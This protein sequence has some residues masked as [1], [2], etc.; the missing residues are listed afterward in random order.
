MADI[1]SKTSGDHPNIVIF[2]PVIL[3]TTVVL[4]CMLQWLLPLGVL[5]GIGQTWRVAI[6]CILVVA[7]I[8]LA[9]AGRRVLTGL[10]TNVSPLRPTT[11]L[12]TGGVY[13]WTRNPL[14]TGGT[15]IMLGI[16]LVFALD[17]LVLLIVP[18]VLILH[19][20]VVT[21]EEQYLEQKF[22]DSYRQY[23]A[24]VA[25]YGFGV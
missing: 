10:G 6:G 8:S 18:S 9:A 22:G 16:A 20:G 2:P 14:Y 21:R 13:Q 23:K 12:A 15:L 17:W 4:G 11:A 3:A 19:F 24:S 5:A 25:R 1:L 7:G